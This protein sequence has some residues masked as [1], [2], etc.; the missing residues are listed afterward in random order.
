[1]ANTVDM[2]KFNGQ[3]GNSVLQWE[4]RYNSYADI[5]QLDDDTEA[6]MTQ[7]FL[8]EHALAFYQSYDSDTKRDFGALISQLQNRYNGCNGLL[9]LI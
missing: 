1:M 2:P 6:K 8:T 7:F 9:N 3:P 4:D 5:L